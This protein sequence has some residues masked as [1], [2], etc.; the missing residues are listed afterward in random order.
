MACINYFSSTLSIPN[1]S[2]PTEGEYACMG[3]S[4]DGTTELSFDEWQKRWTEPDN[5]VIP[6][7]LVFQEILN[8]SGAS[9]T[10][11]NISKITITPSSN[12]YALITENIN[13]KA[14]HPGLPLPYPT[15]GISYNMD[16]SVIYN[17]IQLNIVYSLQFPGF[18]LPYPFF[19]LVMPNLSSN[20]P[21]NTTI[22]N[23][24]TFYQFN[25][26]G[27]Q[28]V[29]N[30]FIY[31]FSKYF[32]N[33]DN[34]KVVLPGQFGYNSFM[35]NLFDGCRQIPGA[36][37]SA[38][39]LMCLNCSRVEISSNYEILSL[40]G[41][42][43]PDLQTLYSINNY[44]PSFTPQCDPLCNNTNAFKLINSG[45][46]TS[47]PLGTQLECQ[48]TVCVVDN[49]SI[50]AAQ[51]SIDGGVN[52]NQ[53]CPA[54][55]LP[56]NTQPCV[57]IVDSTLPGILDRV[58]GGLS[59]FN[60]Y[61]PGARCLSIQLDGSVV[62]V[63]CGSLSV[64]TTNPPVVYSSKLGTGFYIFVGVIFIVAILSIFCL[65]ISDFRLKIMTIDG[66][67]G[68]QRYL[69]RQNQFLKSQ[70]PSGVSSSIYR[71][72]IS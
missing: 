62:N 72:N 60:Q 37:L 68:P 13:Y 32:R 15:L 41:C 1:Y 53:V 38:Q 39:N 50:T 23:S 19:G 45:S 47:L 57:C 44:D 54:C 14:L 59:G 34:H 58:N 27:L 51:S 31:M 40:C 49:V 7:R 65:W 63:P 17:G 3:V 16:A 26:Q 33:A 29:Q 9:G 30:N 55:T 42:V 28:R 6:C 35:E 20:S 52:F 21:S 70:K 48:S 10:T 43:S 69:D 61:C 71:N 4:E 5:S 11:N 36:C 18:P 67:T 46:D 66:K 12:L 22:Q 2:R 64:P 24:G 8:G 25:L 56:G